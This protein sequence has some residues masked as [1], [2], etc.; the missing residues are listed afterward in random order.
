[1]QLILWRH[2][3]ADE[4]AQTGLDLD[5]TLTSRGKKQAA[6]MAAWLK[7]KLPKD[8]VLWVSE[9]VRAQQTA[10][11]LKHPMQIN[12]ELNPDADPH[13]VLEACGWDLSPQS[14]DLLH[15]RTLVLVGHQPYLGQ[16]ASLLQT[17]VPHFWSL[18]KAGVCWLAQRQRESMPVQTYLKMMISTEW[19]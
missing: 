4:Q 11:Y 3:E 13:A 18:K 15:E 14:I 12:A 10:A 17:G 6:S 2:A 16:I 19:L 9:A 7:G 5:R 8:Y 1:M